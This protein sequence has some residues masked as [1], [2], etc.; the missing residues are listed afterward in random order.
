MSD[1]DHDCDHDHEPD[2]EAC[3]LIDGIELDLPRPKAQLLARLMHALDWNCARAL[4]VDEAEAA[5]LMEFA[6]EIRDALREAGVT[7]EGE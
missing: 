7:P 2:G 1:H 3:E 6:G 4:A 5:D